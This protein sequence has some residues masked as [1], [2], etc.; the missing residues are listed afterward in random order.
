MAD[1]DIQTKLTEW[2]FMDP[3]KVDPHKRTPDTKTDTQKNY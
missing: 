1:A 2:T 3:W